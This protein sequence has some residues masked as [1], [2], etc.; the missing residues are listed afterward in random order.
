MGKPP[1]SH[2]G[3]PSSSSSS[4]A[5]RW[6][7]WLGIA[8][9]VSIFV[10]AISSAIIVA[11]SHDKDVETWPIQ[12]AVWL[13]IFSGISNVAYSSALATGIAVRFWLRAAQGTELSQLH[14][15]WE[16]GQGL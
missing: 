8:S 13:A 7:P 10:S 9:L 12:P 11:A 4:A 6:V 3:I 1:Y 15:I 14:Y 16:H 2:A 5:S